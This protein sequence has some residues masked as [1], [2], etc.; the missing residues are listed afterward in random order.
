MK[1]FDLTMYSGTVV[2]KTKKW[3]GPSVKRR[4]PN[5]THQKKGYVLEDINNAEYKPAD[6]FLLDVATIVVSHG[7]QCGKPFFCD[8][9]DLTYFAE[10]KLFGNIIGLLTGD[11]YILEILHFD[12]ERSEIVFYNVIAHRSNL[13]KHIFHVA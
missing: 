12:T 5:G 13:S 3:K 4:K 11:Q 2:K 6:L 9:K 1:I 7:A 8:G 10:R